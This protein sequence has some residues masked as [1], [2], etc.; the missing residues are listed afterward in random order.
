[1]HLPG[2]RSIFSRRQLAVFYMTRSVKKGPYVD[3]KLLK[4]VGKAKAG[5]PAIQTWARASQIAPDF[6]GYTFAVHNGKTFTNVFVTDDMVGHR[7]G[8]FS[9]TTTFRKHG[10]QMQKE[11][12]QKAKQTEIDQAKA[13]KSVATSA[14]K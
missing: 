3:A 7:L 10:G 4:K 13:A 6:V 11:I 12:E 2:I 5:G 1:M 14:K 9:P 8:E